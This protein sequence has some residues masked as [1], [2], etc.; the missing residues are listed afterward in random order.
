MRFYYVYVLKSIYAHYIYTGYTSNLGQR[1]VRHNSKLVISTRKYAPYELIFFEGYKS[2]TDAKRRE[3]YLKTT[4]G[5]VA[6][7]TMLKETLNN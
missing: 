1:L 7:R 3:K 2:M 4:K 6:V 5:K